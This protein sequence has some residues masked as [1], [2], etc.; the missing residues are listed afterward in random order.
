VR[1][2]YLILFF[3]LSVNVLIAQDTLSGNYNSL[4]IQAG[5]HF[6]STV[7]NVKGLLQIQPNAKIEFQD[8]GLIVCESGLICRG[9]KNNIEFYG[10]LNSEGIGF[11]IKNVDTSIIDI[12]GSSF[13]N[14]QFPLFFDF[15]WK[16]KSVNIRECQFADNIGKTSVIQVLNPPFN[17]N[18]DSNDTEFNLTDNVFTNNN[19]SIY[20]ED[21]KSDQLKFN[22]SNNVFYGNTV[23]GFKNYNISTNVL[24][25]R[26][27]QVFSKFNPKIE[28]NSFVFNYLIDNL[29]DTI[30]HPANFG[31]YGTE[32][33]FLLP[34][35]YLG[36]SNKENIVKGIYDQTLNYNAPK[37]NFEPFLEAPSSSN[38]AH[39]YS[40]LT[41]EKKIF[42]DSFPINENLKG[43]VFKSNKN[44]DF[45]KAK[46]RFT[47]FIDDTSLRHIDTLV[48]FDQKPN[49]EE[50]QI[51]FTRNL[52]SK[53]QVGYLT[54]K[55]ASDLQGTSLPSLKIGWPRYLVEYRRRKVLIDSLNLIRAKDS[56]QKPPSPLDSI[57][58]TFQ[59]IEA[60]LKSR[61]EFGLLTGGAIYTG[62][63]SQSNLFKNDI[64]LYIGANINYTIFSNLSG[65]L[66]LSK[67]AI[68]NSDKNSNNSDQLARG[69]SF[70]TSMLGISASTNYDLVD[71]RL[72]TKARKFRPSIGL[73]FDVFSFSPSDVYNGVKYKLQPLGTGGQFTDSTRKPY[74]LLT[75]GYFLNI[76]LKYQLNRFNS[77]GIHLSFHKSLSDYLDDVGPDFYPSPEKILK[78]K[79]DNKDAALYFS[80]PTSRN[81]VG[82]YRN[83]PNDQKDGFI[84][85]GIFYSRR[86]FN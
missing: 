42:T 9:S 62:T 5:N 82:Q 41:L 6:V 85:F 78:S 2:F 19:A 8:N 26:V 83:S 7:V 47:Y 77:V 32:K 22:I 33:D 76:K 50:S 63:V 56:L 17:L 79:I 43:L 81:V 70:T 20:I 45:N 40:I 23:Y 86:L 60:P 13:R 4:T 54:V 51:S 34:N 84:L 59:K 44:V 21:F 65:S 67:F 12:S 74:S 64:N 48:A 53:N 28:N 31:L 75:L 57:K 27:D 68:S 37:I 71:N 10:K 72:Y 14:L 11:V 46:I 36:S 35:N 15:G 3:L 69:M 80:N 38:P 66:T 49:G 39:I 16:R 1:V 25:G 61:L 24:Y 29:S 55:D 58:N 52:P 30:V 73:G 18:V